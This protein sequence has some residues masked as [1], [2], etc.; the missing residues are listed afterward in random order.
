MQKPQLLNGLE[1]ARR[2]IEGGKTGDERP[3]QSDWPKG[4]HF[5]DRV[6]AVREKQGLTQ[7]EFAEK[8]GLPIGTI[9]NWEQSRRASPGAAAELVVSMIEKEPAITAHIVEAVRETE[10]T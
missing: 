2:H 6:K 5:A 8:Y 3:G 10:L 4:M 9:R 1:Q 7:R